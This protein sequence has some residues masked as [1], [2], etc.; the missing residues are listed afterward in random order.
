MLADACRLLKTL[1]EL[2]EDI[3]TDFALGK[4]AGAQS[5]DRRCLTLPGEANRGA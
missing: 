1:H 2:L 3:L 5:L 4:R